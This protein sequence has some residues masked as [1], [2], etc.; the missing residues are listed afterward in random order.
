[1]AGSRGSERFL[2]NDK[3]QFDKEQSDLVKWMLNERYFYT[4]KLNWENFN[5]DLDHD[6]L[7]QE[8]T[9]EIFLTSAC[10]QQCEYCYLIK[11][12]NLYPQEYN[13]QTIILKNLKILFNYLIEQQYYIPNIEFFTGEIWH[14]NFGLQVLQI[15]LEAIQNGLH[16]DYILI[17]SNC[18]FVIQDEQMFKIQNYIDKYSQ[19][20][21]KLGF[22][23]SI[24]GAFLENENRPLVNGYIKTEEF[25]DKL[26][27]FAQHNNFLFHPMVAAANIDKWIENYQWWEKKCQEYGYNIDGSVM[28]LEVRND[29]WTEQSIAEYNNFMNYLIDKNFQKHNKDIG[30]FTDNLFDGSGIG[31]YV[32]YAPAKTDTF[33]GCTVA[34]SLTLRVG[35][36]AICPC[37]RTG[38][39]KFIYGKFIVENDKIVDFEGYNPQIAMKILYSNFNLTNIGC[40]TCTY[41][42]YCLKGCYGSQFEST[43]EIFAPIQ[44]VC[45]F[46]KAKWNN[47]VSKY[48]K[49]GVHKYLKEH[50]NPLDPY[51]IPKQEWLKFSERILS[52]GKL[53]LSN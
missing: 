44:C 11:Y 42:D 29:N 25:Y 16:T 24:D 31:G 23:I 20:G 9:L 52:N 1:M 39:D 8:S 50:L 4:W 17:P 12:P 15:T 53:N 41:S 5:G 45:D 19:H 30:M 51:Y 27:L 14:S 6:T 36:L 35:D 22:S 49:M 48:E 3:T 33:P 34:N 28:M 43:G 38:Y 18:S 13:N 32:P 47:I 2:N 46:D 7:I 10:N 37:H 21:V 26:F 40:D